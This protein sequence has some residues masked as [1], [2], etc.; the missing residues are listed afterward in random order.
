MQLLNIE[1]LKLVV[2]IAIC[3]LPG[4]IG[5]VILAS[6]EEKKREIRNMVC[7]R[8]FGVSNAIQY[9]EFARFL[10]IVAIATLLFSGVASWFLLLRG[11]MTGQ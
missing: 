8:L 9:P 5:I 10:M 11:M 1:F 2:K 3:V 6:S 4:V 7:N